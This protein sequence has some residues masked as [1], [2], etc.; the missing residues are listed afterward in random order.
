MVEY[1]EKFCAEL[2]VQ[3]LLDFSI[4][5]QGKIKGVC[6]LVSARQYA[7]NHAFGWRGSGLLLDIA[8][9]RHRTRCR[10]HFPRARMILLLLLRLLVQQS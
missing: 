7:R 3:V 6:L 1:I 9:K 10:V 5:D 8:T 4:L 2:Q